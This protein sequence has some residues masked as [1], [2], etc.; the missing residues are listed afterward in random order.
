MRINALIHTFNFFLL[1]ESVDDIGNFLLV[2]TCL[3]HNCGSADTFFRATYYSQYL[4]GIGCRSHTLLL[5]CLF[6]MLL[7]FSIVLGGLK[8]KL[9]LVLKVVLIQLAIAS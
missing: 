2:K 1:P 5:G 4:I 3:L 9:C 6:R 8:S 7:S